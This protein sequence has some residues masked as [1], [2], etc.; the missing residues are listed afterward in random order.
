M[1]NFHSAFRI[2]K[3]AFLQQPQDPG[4]VLVFFALINLFDMQTFFR[5]NP[6]PTKVEAQPQNQSCL[7]GA[8]QEWFLYDQHSCA[9]VKKH[10]RWPLDAIYK[11]TTKLSKN[12]TTPAGRYPQHRKEWCELKKQRSQPAPLST[13]K[14]PIAKFNG[15]KNCGQSPKGPILPE[16]FRK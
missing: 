2:S 5:P 7:H 8:T 13:K 6:N 11:I 9:P 12:K 4:N 16:F 1:L 14:W 15:F 10:I 3:S